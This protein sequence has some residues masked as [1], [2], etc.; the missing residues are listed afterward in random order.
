MDNWLAALKAEDR[1]LDL[2]SGAGSFDYTKYACQAVAMDIDL[3]SLRRACGR[4]TAVAP[5]NASSHLLPFKTGC[6]D[7]VVFLQLPPKAIYPAI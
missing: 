1:V 5:V 7:L 3:G 6:F 4:A 2:G